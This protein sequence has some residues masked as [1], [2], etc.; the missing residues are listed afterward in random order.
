MKKICLYL[1]FI[2]SQ[3]SYSHKEPTHQYLTIEAYNLLRLNLGADIPDMVNHLHTATPATDGGPWQLAY[4]TRGAFRED[5]EDPVYR[6]WM[7]N[8]PTLYGNEAFTIPI[9][10]PTL[11]QIYTFFGGSDPFIS[12]SHFWKADGSDIGNSNMHVWASPIDF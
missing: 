9:V 4:L 7:G 10:Q 6:Y 12:V 2:C 5:V 11:L 8:H 3:V 1:L